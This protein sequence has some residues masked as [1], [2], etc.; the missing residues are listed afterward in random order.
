[1]VEEGLIVL[2]NV[3]IIKYAYRAEGLGQ[4]EAVNSPANTPMQGEQ[5]R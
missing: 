1:M 3:D 4:A 5:S 2:S